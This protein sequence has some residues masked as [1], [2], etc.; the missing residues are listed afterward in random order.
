MI[1]RERIDIRDYSNSVTP[2]LRFLRLTASRRR[3]VFPAHRASATSFNPKPL[4]FGE[5]ICF[6]TRSVS[7]ETE[8]RRA[9]LAYASGYEERMH[10]RPPGS[11]V[12]ILLAISPVC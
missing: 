5:T 10:A 1:S 11:G 4:K 6:I 2:P 3:L 9:F 8:E 7:E 12:S